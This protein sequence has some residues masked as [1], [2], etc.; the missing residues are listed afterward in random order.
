MAESAK[1]RF[2]GKNGNGIMT[3]N[4]SSHK[5]LNYDNEVI[6]TIPYYDCFHVE[7]INLV[8]SIFQC[9]KKWLDTGCG[10]GNLIEKALIEFPDFKFYLADPSDDMLSICEKKFDNSQVQIIGI[11]D[12]ASINIDFQVDIITAIQSHH[13]MDT[14][15]REIATKNCFDL[16]RDN[17]IYITFE[18]IKPDSH[19]GIENCLKRWGDYQLKKGRYKP[20][21]EKHKN[22]FD[23]KYFPIKISEHLDLMRQTGFRFVELFWMSNMQAGLYGIK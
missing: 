4:L 10:T 20:D 1:I 13:Y 14:S 8:K 11:H 9:S 3:D 2:L 6:K 12:T 15:S 19:F 21:V 17:G 16:L 5:S 7:T 23:K 22:R 18:N